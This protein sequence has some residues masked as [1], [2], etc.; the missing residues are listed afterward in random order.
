MPG[1]EEAGYLKTTCGKR[2]R[3]PE[4]WRQVWLSALLS[5]LGFLA[6]ILAA[7][8]TGR[9]AVR[10]AGAV[11][12]PLLGGCGVFAAAALLFPGAWESE[13][14]PIF[15]RLYGLGLTVLF[16]G[17]LCR[18]I[19]E[20][21]SRIATYIRMADI[22]GWMIAAAGLIVLALAVKERY[23]YGEQEGREG[24]GLFHHKHE[25]EQK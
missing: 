11:L 16:F 2:K 21:T 4:R 13:F 12:Y 23:E 8:L 5:L 1:R 17:G 25:G 3:P 20:E 9:E 22:A 14:Y 19:W 18:G 7:V 10:F 15:A 24:R 6:C